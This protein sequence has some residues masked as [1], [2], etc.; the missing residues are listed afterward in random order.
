MRIN[1]P[2]LDHPEMTVCGWQLPPS[3]PPPP[4]PCVTAAGVMVVECFCQHHCPR[5]LSNFAVL[6]D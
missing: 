4:P 2:K 6:I 5:E 1:H 3:P